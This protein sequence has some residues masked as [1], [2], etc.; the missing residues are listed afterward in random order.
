MKET[1]RTTLIILLISTSS[2]CSEGIPAN[3]SLN[4]FPDPINMFDD[5]NQQRAAAAPPV[6]APAVVASAF[7]EFECVPNAP[8]STAGL[9]SRADNRVEGDENLSVTYYDPGGATAF[10][11]QARALERFRSDRGS[12]GVAIYVSD[13]RATVTRAIFARYPDARIEGDRLV[14]PSMA[15][16]LALQAADN[17][18]TRIA[19]VSGG[20]ETIQ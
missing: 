8:I 5:A 10:G 7:A 20:S 17:N 11:L 16:H 6:P 13:D 2:S 12:S 18:W 15:G 19:C 4:E 9:E 3:E 14:S 1:C